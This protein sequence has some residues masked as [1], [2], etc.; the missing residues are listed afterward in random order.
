MEKKDKHQPG[1]DI[2]HRNIDEKHDKLDDHHEKINAVYEHHEKLM[3]TAE[4]LMKTIENRSCRFASSPFSTKNPSLHT[5]KY[6]T[7]YVSM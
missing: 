2:N 5:S 7:I 4:K 3:K 6:T 1:S